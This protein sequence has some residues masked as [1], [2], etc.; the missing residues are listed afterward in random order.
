MEKTNTLTLAN[1]LAS[2]YT[3]TE[4]CIELKSINPQSGYYARAFINLNLW[5]NSKAH[6]VVPFFGF[7]YTLIEQSCVEL[8]AKPNNKLYS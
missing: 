6:Y 4:F 8:V 5:M 3:I 7:A 1:A 2:A